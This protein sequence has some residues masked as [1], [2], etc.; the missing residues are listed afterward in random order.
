[1][2]EC[3]FSC[4]PFLQRRAYHISR[5]VC[6]TPHCRDADRRAGFHFLTRVL[7]INNLKYRNQNIE[8]RWYTVLAD[9]YYGTALY[10]ATAVII[11]EVANA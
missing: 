5:H 11:F 7:I 6:R 9:I 2:A 1:M 4:A 10:A 8:W 3:T